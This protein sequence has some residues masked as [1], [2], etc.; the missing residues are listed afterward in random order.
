METCIII[1]TVTVP[2]FVLKERLVMEETFIYGQEYR[3]GMG[4]IRLPEGE[5]FTY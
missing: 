1:N 2:D 5:I 3:L 4:K